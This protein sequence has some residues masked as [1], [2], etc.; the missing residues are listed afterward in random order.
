MIPLDLQVSQALGSLRDKDF[1]NA[2]EQYQN[3]WES[4]S[5][6]LSYAW[7]LG[8]G[9]LLSNQE[10][11]AYLLWSTLLMELEGDAQEDLSQHLDGQA[12]YYAAH[13]DYSEAALLRQHLQEIDPHN[14]NNVLSLISIW[15]HLNQITDEDMSGL[16]LEEKFA[17]VTE[18]DDL[19]LSL[20]EA[21]IEIV[22][23][24]RIV[25]WWPI[26]L[27]E[28]V[29][30]IIPHQKRLFAIL[31]FSAIDLG[32]A[33][34][35]TK[36]AVLY[37]EAALRIEPTNSEALSHRSNMYFHGGLLDAALETAQ[38][39]YHQA[40]TLEAKID[41]NYLIL[42]ALLRNGGSWQEAQVC[43]DRHVDLLEDLLKEIDKGKLW[44]QVEIGQVINCSF[45]YPYIQ[46]NPHQARR[47]QNK[48]IQHCQDSI[49]FDNQEKI[50]IYKDFHA[51]RKDRLD[52]KEFLK[53]GYLSNC[54]KS[55]SVGWLARSL[56]HHYDRSQYKI[57]CY[58]IL[59]DP[60]SQNSL[61]NWYVQNVDYFYDL[62]IDYSV[63]CDRIFEDKIDILID[64][65]SFTTDVNLAILSSKPAP[66]QATWLG[67]DAWGLNAVDYYIADS[68]ALPEVAQS[69]YPE[70]LFRLPN[71]YLAIDGFEIGVPTLKR[72]D[73]GIPQDAI[74]YFSGQ[75]GYKRHPDTVRLQMEIIKAVP[76]SYFLIKDIIQNCQPIK[77][78]FEDLAENVGL[79]PNRLRFLS[80]VDSEMTH[81]ANLALA[82]IVLD[83]YPYNGAT[84]TL[85]TLWMGIPLVTR[86]GQQFSARNS[87]TF[88]MNA[89]ITEGIAWTDE[90]YV[91]WGIRLGTDEQLRKEVAW[92]LRQSRKSA[93][94]WNGQQFTRDMEAA[95]RQM[96]ERYCHG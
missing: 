64:L 6:E 4:E 38:E 46:D 35:A 81:R 67:W 33:K 82:D 8:I 14:L 1:E 7:Y 2:I 45:F 90:E 84:T 76:N 25:A 9:L 50:A 70:K 60:N 94:L 85:E 19:D 34:G 16:Q 54:F 31:M 41:A 30:E 55:H 62:G 24:R 36:L 44:S 48:I 12:N 91:E 23:R 72:Q 26:R 75:T 40:L 63:A 95:Y 21:T 68:Y 3:L 53:I 86:V 17:E 15:V 61:R 59:G 51:K 11:E 28:T 78:F 77:D 39:F 43:V 93:P 88:M 58:S 96:W 47:F 56:I 22:C 27:I 92:K 74:V 5:T 57:Y 13:Q 32:Y 29:L 79:N 80:A 42:K 83:T 10:A 49:E 66:I 18:K 87:Y 69:Y 65:D 37:I 73:L 52:S 20:L 89:G 71:P